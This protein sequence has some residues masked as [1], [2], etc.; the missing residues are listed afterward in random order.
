M[1][2]PHLSSYNNLPGCSV[3]AT[4]SLIDGKWKC[5]ILFHLLG[6]MLRFNQIKRLMPCV[7]QRML[8]AQLRALEADGLISRTVFPQVPP[9]VEYEITERGRSLEPLLLVAKAWG[10]DHMHLFATKTPNAEPGSD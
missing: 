7:T 5:A 1:A 10:D 4:F 8:T 6:S 9:R 2:K 3:E